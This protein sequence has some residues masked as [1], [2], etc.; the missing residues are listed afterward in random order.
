MRPGVS[1]VKGSFSVLERFSVFWIVRRSEK[2]FSRTGFLFV[3]LIMAGKYSL[4]V[5]WKLG[6]MVAKE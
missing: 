4:R 1:M 3:S 2:L 5:F 6:T